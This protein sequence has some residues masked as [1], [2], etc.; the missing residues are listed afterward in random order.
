VYLMKG[1]NH[2]EVLIVM[3]GQATFHT[4]LY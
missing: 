3:T 4:N 1:N 2:Q